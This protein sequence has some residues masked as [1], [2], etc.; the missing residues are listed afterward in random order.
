MGR[1]AEFWGR[2]ILDQFIK[3]RCVFKQMFKCARGY[4]NV[5]F[6]KKCA[7]ASTRGCEFDICASVVSCSVPLQRKSRHRKNNIHV[8]F[9]LIR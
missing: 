2:K 7:R 5:L 4:L 8:V 3:S 6:K 9:I 1:L